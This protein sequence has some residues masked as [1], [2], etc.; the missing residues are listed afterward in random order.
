VTSAA[1]IDQERGARP[2][3]IATV[4]TAAAVALTR[5][6]WPVFSPTPYAPVFAAVAIA[7]HWGH[8][9]AGLVAI[10]LSGLAAATLF[11]TSGAHAWNG[12]T[13]AGFALV[14]LVGNRLI[15]GRNKATAALRASEAQ[16]RATLADLRASEDALRRAQ[17]VEAVGQLAAGVA[18]NF[19]NLLTVTM[20]YTEVLEDAGIGEDQRRTAI[21]EIRRATDRGA[22]LARQMLAFGRRHD[23]KLSRVALD[24]TL[25]GMR[26]MLTGVIREDIRLTVRAGAGGAVLID[27]HDLE[28]L[29][30][31]LVMNARDALPEGGDIEIESSI[32]TIAADDRRLD[33]GVAPGDYL[34]VRV[35]DNGVGMSAQVQAHLFEPFFTT[36]EVG[37]GTGLGLAFVHGI[38]QHAGGFVS[39]DSAPGRGTTVAVYLPPAPAAVAEPAPEPPTAP[40]PAPAAAA[41]ILVVE[42][43]VAVRRMTVQVLSRA[44]YQVLAAATPAEAQTI[45]A[46]H[47]RQISLLLTDVVMPE[48]H[49]PQLAERLLASRPDLPVLFVSGYGDAMLP[50]GAPAANHAF[51]AKPFSVPALTAAIAGLLARATEG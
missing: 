21:E 6:T 29:I 4:A 8:G 14:A 20:G 27:P 40:R 43:E 12:A 34:V 51:L 22:A 18:H 41:T 19:N 17:K 26:D 31:N 9:R 24:R 47:P 25:A 10:V 28:Q 35:R 45:F 48:M 42:D 36:K 49:G 5:F 23:P 11:P 1:T 16:L 30:F 37:E 46:Q 15:A 38:A 44:G 3:I 50:A 2:Y 33:P 39:V 32:V 7:T 13:L